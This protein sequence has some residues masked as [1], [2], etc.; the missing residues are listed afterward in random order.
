[1]ISW[2]CLRHSPMV[3]DS[4]PSKGRARSSSDRKRSLLLC[5]WFVCT[6]SSRGAGQHRVGSS[7]NAEQV[8]VFPIFRMELF[9]QI[10]HN[11]SVCRQALHAIGLE[12]QVDCTGHAAS[13]RHCPLL[14]FSGVQKSCQRFRCSTNGMYCI[15]TVNGS[16]FRRSAKVTERTSA[17]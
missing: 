6:I 1:M 8:P 16:F 17:W 14:L 7:C 11:M 4:R 10:G 12:R 15:Y 9:F 5:I 3:A 13:L 2:I